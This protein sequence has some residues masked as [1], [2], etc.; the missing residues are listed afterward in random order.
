[1]LIPQEDV[2]SEIRW[3]DI[4]YASHVL[5]YDND[6]TIVAKARNAIKDAL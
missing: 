6:K 2:I 3:V 4:S 1:M 5:S